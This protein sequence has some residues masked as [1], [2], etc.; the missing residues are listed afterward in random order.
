MNPT[1]CGIIN[2][3]NKNKKDM[4]KQQLE[5]IAFDDR[6]SFDGG[7]VHRKFT[8][9]WG[10]SGII[11]MEQIPTLVTT[12]VKQRAEMIKYIAALHDKIDWILEKNNCCDMPSCL[13][14]GCTSD[15]K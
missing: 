11:N 5:D 12:L 4:T 7:K 2:K 15:H 13:T 8:E 1:T 14:S 3:T 9:Q 10:N 6:I